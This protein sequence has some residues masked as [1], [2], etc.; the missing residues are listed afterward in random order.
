MRYLLCG[1]L[2]LFLLT[3][4]ATPS[5]PQ[6]N[7]A[8]SK[9]VV[10]GKFKHISAGA[11]RVARVNGFMTVNAQMTNTSRHNRLVYYRFTWLGKDGFPVANEEGWKTITLYAKQNTFIPAIAPVPQA[12][13]FRLEVKTP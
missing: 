2:A 8:A 10:M 6:P 3:G 5:P 12:R 11:I 7:S 1:A 4:C 9:I 13:D